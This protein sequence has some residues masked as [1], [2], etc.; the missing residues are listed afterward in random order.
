MRK[1]LGEVAQTASHLFGQEERETLKRHKTSVLALGQRTPQAVAELIATPGET[2]IPSVDSLDSQ[3]VNNSQDIRDLLQII[4]TV[5]ASTSGE[6]TSLR[7]YEQVWE[8]PE[9]EPAIIYCYIFSAIPE[10]PDHKVVAFLADGQ[11]TDFDENGNGQIEVAEEGVLAGTLYSVVDQIFI[12]ALNGELGVSED[13]FED[14]WGTF[15]SASIPILDDD[16]SVIATLGID[17][18]VDGEANRLR[19]VFWICVAITIV[20]SLLS[21]TVAFFTATYLNRPLKKITEGTE[22]IRKGKFET[23]VAIS[24]RDEFGFLAETFNNM[25]KEIELH[26]NRQEALKASY[27]RFVPQE[28]LNQLQHESLLEVQLGDHVQKNMTVLFS[29]IRKFTTIFR[30]PLAR[31]EL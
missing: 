21:I 2:Y 31:E 14:R 26:I 18:S 22:K 24:T 10:S 7:S 16:G 12:D 5:R 19:D 23:R 11:P 28:M 25:A 8:N 13:W 9:Q 27:Y 1:R 30:K 29:D 4:W 17:Y 3:L 15:I 20:V 6:I